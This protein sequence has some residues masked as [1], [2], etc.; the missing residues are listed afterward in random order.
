MKVKVTLYGNAKHWLNPLKSTC[1]K[2]NDWNF[3]TKKL[4]PIDIFIY[5]MLLPTWKLVQP[6]YYDDGNHK[7]DDSSTKSTTFYNFELFYLS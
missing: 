4:F 3:L 2:E 1:K 6:N 7:N 5:K